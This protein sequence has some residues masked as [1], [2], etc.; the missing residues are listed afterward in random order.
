MICLQAARSGT[1]MRR[2]LIQPFAACF[3]VGEHQRWEPFRSAFFATITASGVGRLR[4]VV[5]F[6]P[7]HCRSVVDILLQYTSSYGQG[8]R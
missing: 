3:R 6:M 7:V 8:N 5:D 2:K 1:R 4:Q